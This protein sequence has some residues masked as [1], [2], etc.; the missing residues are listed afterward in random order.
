MFCTEFFCYNYYME[1]YRQIYDL[2][3]SD[4]DI[5]IENLT[6][7]LNL[8]EPLLMQLKQFLNSPAKRIRPLLA[9]LYMKACD[10]RLET[11]HYKLL[12]AIELVHN[13]SLIHDDVIDNADIRRGIKTLN[14]IFNSKLAVVS[15]DYLLSCAV[16]FVREIGDNRIL[17]IFIQSLAEMCKGEVA[18]YFCANKIPAM[19]EYLLKTEQKTAQLF[20]AALECSAILSPEID[21]EKAVS[22]AKNFGIAF[23]I[24][25]DLN[26]ILTTNTDAENGIYTAPIILSGDVDRPAIEKTYNLLNNYINLALNNLDSLKDNIYKE[27]LLALTELYR[28]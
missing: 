19:D 11:E 20:V 12:T 7:K 26:N 14:R 10:V 28:K 15:G 18:Q 2:V 5:I 24:K 21:K 1:N 4:I 6:C 16:D 3:K 17:N 8:Q 25:D 27:A 9:I 13:A 23:Q 22:F